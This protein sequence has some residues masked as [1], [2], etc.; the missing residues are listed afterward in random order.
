MVNY[1]FFSQNVETHQVIKCWFSPSSKIC[2]K[3]TSGSSIFLA[4]YKRFTKFGPNGYCIIKS[5]FWASF[6]LDSY[7]YTDLLHLYRSCSLSVW[8]SLGAMFVDNLQLCSF[9]RPRPSF[10]NG[11]SFQS[12]FFAKFDSR[13]P[14]EPTYRKPKPFTRP[15]SRRNTLV[16]L[17]KWCKAKSSQ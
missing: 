2:Q 9:R 7:T 12:S 13:L 1:W 4:P 16:G 5:I 6:Y 17:G 10:L 11:K 15:S 3:L 14:R 8:S